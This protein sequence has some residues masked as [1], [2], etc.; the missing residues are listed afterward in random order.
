VGHYR[1]GRYREAAELFA[2]ARDQV[3]DDPKVSNFLATAYLHGKLYKPSRAEF[4]RMLALQPESVEPRLG[5]ARIAVR[6]GDFTEAL[7]LFREVLEREPTHMVALYNL[8]RLEYRAGNYQEAE[9][10]ITKVL[11]Q[12]ENH[13]Q[14]RYIL[15]QTYSR[16]G[17][18]DKAEQEFL[19]VVKLS[20]RN[21]QAHFNLAAVYRRVGNEEAA[22]KGEEDFRRLQSQQD[23]DRAAEGRAGDRFRKEDFE[24]A[25]REFD[26]LAEVSPTNGW[27]Q[28]A[29]GQCFFK[30]QRA[31]EAITAFEE[32]ARLDPQLP[33]PYYFLAML[34]QGRGEYDKSQRARLEFEKLEAM[35]DSDQKQKF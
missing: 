14:A 16:L 32:A 18:D 29:R 15:G 17:Q 10:F 8:G 12:E 9:K 22:R 2:Q 13:W 33:E 25:L 4:E 5:L 19:P 11:D 3:P 34:Y 28:V 1:Q 31:D 26:R 30:L 23:S 6:F 21:A 20:P 27:Y 35:S 7:R 24:G